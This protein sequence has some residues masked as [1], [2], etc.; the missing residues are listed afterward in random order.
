MVYSSLVVVPSSSEVHRFVGGGGM[1]IVGVLRRVWIPLVILVVIVSGGFIVSRVHGLFGAQN[2]ASYD[3]AQV[4]S[5]QSYKPKQLIYEVFGPVGTVA[6]ISYFDVNY[7]PQQVDGA[8]LPWSL[9][10]TSNTQSVVGSVVAQGDSDNIGCRILV[11][12][13][14]KAEKIS[15]NVNAYTH[16]LVTG[17]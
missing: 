16:C 11:D 12:G 17:G 14:V 5:G 3:G 6:K 1:R 8:A 10:I 13:Q 9:K 7:Q 4:D 15:D 2:H